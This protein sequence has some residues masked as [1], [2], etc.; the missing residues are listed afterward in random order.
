MMG[1]TEEMLC[2]PFAISFRDAT[3][4]DV[5]AVIELVHSAYRG[6]ASRAGWTTEADLL[7]GNRTDAS[8]VR[9]DISAA[10]SVIV[11][12]RRTQSQERPVAMDHVEADATV[13][14]DELLA[15]CHL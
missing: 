11:L 2:S 15:C 10:R 9:A 3:L 4:S 6:E 7:D 1:H 14:I 5:A 13:A 12:A 8:I